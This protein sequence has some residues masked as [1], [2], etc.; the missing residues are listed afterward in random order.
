MPYRIYKRVVNAAKNLDYWDKRERWACYYCTHSMIPNEQL[1]IEHENQCKKKSE[2]VKHRNESYIRD[3][4]LTET[5]AAVK[6]FQEKL[7]QVEQ[8][9][10]QPHPQD[11][12]NGSQHLWPGS[13]L[14]NEFEP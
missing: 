3:P 11:L 8:G 13:G 4:D 2:K 1:A 9:I 6:R 14:G 12:P 7:R 5:I 10:Y